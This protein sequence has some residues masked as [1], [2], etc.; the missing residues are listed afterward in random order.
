MGQVSS[1]QRSGAESGMDET[2][3]AVCGAGQRM[4]GLGRRWRGSG[5]EGL[6]RRK[7]VCRC[8][9]CRHALKRALH[10]EIISRPAWGEPCHVCRSGGVCSCSF[11]HVEGESAARLHLYGCIHS[12]HWRVAPVSY[13]RQPVVCC[14]GPPRY[15]QISSTF[16]NTCIR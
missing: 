10:E 12:S 9:G 13:L 2:C 7:Q 11:G 8:G 15:D 14:Q 5:M 1:E 6:M 3:G 16:S 4:K